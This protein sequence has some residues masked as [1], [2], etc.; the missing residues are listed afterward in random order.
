[1]FQSCVGMAMEILESSQSTNSTFYSD[2]RTY[3]D[4]LHRKGETDDAFEDE[5]FF[6]LPAISV[7]A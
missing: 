7:Q 2:C 3:F 4:A 5:F 6:T 1:M